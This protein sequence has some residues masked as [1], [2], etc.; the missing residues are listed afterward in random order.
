MPSPVPLHLCL[1]V[2]YI[3]LNE[4]NII[5]LCTTK[6]DCWL[7]VIYNYNDY[8]CCFRVVTKHMNRMLTKEPALK[9]YKKKRD[10]KNTH[11]YCTT[12]KPKKRISIEKFL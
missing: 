7:Y 3:L 2:Y 6:F 5:C 9:K 8:L 10:G 11:L 12:N 4:M 1:F